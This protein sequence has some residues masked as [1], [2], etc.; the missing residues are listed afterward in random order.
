MSANVRATTTSKSLDSDPRFGVI[1]VFLAAAM[2]I[3]P[4]DTGFP[5]NEA[6]LRTEVTED[7]IIGEVELR[8]VG[9]AILIKA[10]LNN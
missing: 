2:L 6:L 9:E 3:L 4:R 10:V 8:Q 1:L 5:G 7:I